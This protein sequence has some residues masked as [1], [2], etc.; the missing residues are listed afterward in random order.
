M[1]FFV[2]MS[3]VV[4]FGLVMIVLV[5][6]VMSLPTMVFVFPAE[7]HG[8]GCH[9]AVGRCGVDQRRGFQ[10]AGNV[11]QPAFFRLCAGAM[12]EPGEVVGRGIEHQVNTVFFHRHLQSGMAVLVGAGIVGGQRHRCQAAGGD[13]TSKC[14]QRAWT[15]GG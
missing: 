2:M 5:V 6:A 14:M 4:M 3:F 12:L 1:M 9:A 7:F 10:P 13:H 11:R 15:V 8:C